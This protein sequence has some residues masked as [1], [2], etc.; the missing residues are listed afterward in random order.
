[1][2][3]SVKLLLIA[4]EALAMCSPALAA[5]KT[6]VYGK[7]QAAIIASDPGVVDE[8]VLSHHFQIFDYL[9]AYKPGEP[10]LSL[11][12]AERYLV[13]QMMVKRSPFPA[14][15]V[16]VSGWNNDGCDACI[17]TGTAAV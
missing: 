15:D 12:F 5:P 10:K 11:L 8:E 3:N 7:A 13:F 14:K 4:L 1:M 6:L 16:Q 17:F 9:L 2:K